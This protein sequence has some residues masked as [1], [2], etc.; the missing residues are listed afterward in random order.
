MNSWW[1]HQMETF[2]ALLALFGEFTGHQRIPHTKPVTRN[3]DVFFD[4]R[5]NQQW[6]KQ[7]RRRWFETPSHSLRHHCNAYA[8]YHR[9]QGKYHLMP[10]LTTHQSQDEFLESQLGGNRQEIVAAGKTIDCPC[11]CSVASQSSWKTP[12]CSTNNGTRFENIYCFT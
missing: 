1:R 6:S 5:L 9:V 8:V 12:P 2:S 10:R 3:F 4:L 7:W 11:R